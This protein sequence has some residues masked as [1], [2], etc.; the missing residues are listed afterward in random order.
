MCGRYY[1]VIDESKEGKYIQNLLTQFSFFQFEQGEIFPSQ[2]VLALLNE[3][4]QIVPKV[5][6]WG[7]EMNHK[8]IINARRETIKEK[9][10][11]QKMLHNRCVIPCNYFFEWQKQ[12]GQKHKYKIGKQGEEMIYL[13]GLYDCDRLVILTGE[14]EKEMCKLHHRTPLLLNHQNMQRYLNGQ[15]EASVDNDDLS[16]F[17]ADLYRQFSLFDV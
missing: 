12:D 15:I 11:F 9:I 4:N 1:F 6:T 7:I 14:A 13:A 8:L 2:E 17:S 16:I 5:F 10:T 3:K